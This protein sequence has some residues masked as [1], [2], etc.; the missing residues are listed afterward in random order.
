MRFSKITLFIVLVVFLSSLF[1]QQI[2]LWLIN[3]F[4]RNQIIL[5]SCSI[6]TLFILIFLAQKIKQGHKKRKI[7][8]TAILVI[9][10]ALLSLKIE[11]FAERVHLFEFGLLGWFVAKDF[12]RSKALQSRILIRT[13]VFIL[14]ISS[15]D[16]F[17]Q[18]LLPYRVGQIRDV[19]FNLCGG[20]TGWI[21]YLLF[22]SRKA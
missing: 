12:S 9:T 13:L 1:A 22:Y 16:E 20:L 6:F 3:I 10:G 11:L 14:F 19:L 21:I 4:G 18:Q 2:W 8:Y 17:L 7:L 15:A 5:F